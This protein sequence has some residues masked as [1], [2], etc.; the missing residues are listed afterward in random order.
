[1]IESAPRIGKLG[2]QR[3]RLRPEAV[4]RGRS[5]PRYGVAHMPEPD[6]VG[7]QHRA[8]AKQGKSIAA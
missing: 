3:R 8:A 1:M 6:G 2:E 4:A 7:L 5:I